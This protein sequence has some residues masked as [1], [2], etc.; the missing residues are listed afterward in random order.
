MAINDYA[1][2][3]ATEEVHILL[4]KRQNVQSLLFSENNKEAK[5]IIIFLFAITFCLFCLQFVCTD[6]TCRAQI[7]HR[8]V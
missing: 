3:H 7:R 4:E 8:N 1:T 6:K 5:L 2:K